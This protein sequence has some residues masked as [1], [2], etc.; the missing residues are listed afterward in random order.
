MKTIEAFG[1]KEHEIRE[2]IV[3]ETLH[4]MEAL[5][6]AEDDMY[7]NGENTLQHKLGVK[8]VNRYKGKFERNIELLKVLKGG[9]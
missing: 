1:K 8:M 6:E 2:S 4:Y 9:E 5:D 7:S 3:R